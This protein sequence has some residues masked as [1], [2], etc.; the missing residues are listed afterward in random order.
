MRHQARQFLAECLEG[1]QPTAARLQ[2]IASSFSR[3]ESLWLDWKS[4]QIAKKADLN[5]EVRR[6]V[7]G[8]AN[9]DG[10]VLVLGYHEQDRTFDDFVAKGGDSKEWASR[11][12]G[13]VPSVPPPRIYEAMVEDKRVLII[14]VPRS[15]ALVWCVERG[16]QKY[17]LRV[18]DQTLEMPP[19]LQM[20]LLLGRRQRPSLVPK[21][22]FVVGERLD[23]GSLNNTKI[24]R[25]RLEIAVENNS[26]QFVEDVRVGFVSYRAGVPNRDLPGP[27]LER[28][29]V[30]RPPADV[31]PFQIQVGLFRQILRYDTL[32]PL[33][34]GTS[35]AIELDLPAI[36]SLL[37]KKGYMNLDYI[38]SERTH[39]RLEFG[40]AIYVFARNA[41][42]TWHQFLI[43]TGVGDQVAPEI[44]V[45]G[46]PALVERPRISMRF[47]RR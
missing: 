3:D 8:F 23:H 19:Y 10:G 28:L 7:S 15:E 2:E 13:S 12:I 14:A 33:S 38:P 45:V 41:P 44:E 9:A 31:A 37:P 18:G 29:E 20:D 30:T 35:S 46:A 39:G 6:A 17:Y 24:F 22:S 1:E 40:G 26:L 4:G 25:I 42:P 47:V 32:E 21:L 43:W 11:I 34:V 16:E 5:D 36:E 27:L